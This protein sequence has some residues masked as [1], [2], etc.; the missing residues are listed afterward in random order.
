M[1]KAKRKTGAQLMREFL[2][3]IG[4]LE[5]RRELIAV[6]SLNGRALWKRQEVF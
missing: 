2:E 6:Y 3:E 4:T 5:P 1:N